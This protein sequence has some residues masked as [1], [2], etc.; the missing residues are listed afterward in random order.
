[1]QYKQATSLRVDQR[2]YD[3]LARLARD[4]GTSITR[5]LEM[6]IQHHLEAAVI[7]DDAPII[8]PVLERVISENLEAT[9][10]ARIEAM[11]ERL[12]G[13]LAKMATDTAVLYLMET[14][15]L[16]DR[17]RDMWRKVAVDH[18]RG[19]IVEL[20]TD[21][22]A[23]D[24]RAKLKRQVEELSAKVLHKDQDLAEQAGKYRAD[25]Q[26]LEVKTQMLSAALRWH[27]T[28]LKVLE[29]EWEASG[30]ILGRRKTFQVCVAEYERR[31]RRPE[32]A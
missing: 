17:E 3:R 29:E 30:G 15:R 1:V 21:T 8:K 10:T 6:A 19:R 7:E 24:E 23:A 12:A 2:L 27:K 14:R 13:L 18:V 16:D 20:Q 22:A 31:E 28:L 25:V 11:K 4:R 26:H 5:Q 32:G 9:V